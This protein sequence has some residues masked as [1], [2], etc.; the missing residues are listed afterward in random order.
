[1]IHRP[2][3]QKQMISTPLP[4]NALRPWP[5]NDLEALP[6]VVPSGTEHCPTCSCD[7]FDARTSRILDLVVDLH[8]VLGTAAE[9]VGT[10]RTLL[11]DEVLP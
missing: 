2:R 8:E 10:V 1:M 9:Q 6:P 7:Q 5:A 11:E 4:A 3:P